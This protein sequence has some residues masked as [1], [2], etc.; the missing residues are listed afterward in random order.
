MELD[1]YFF[2]DEDTTLKFYTVRN[3]RLAA[4]VE[5]PTSVPKH[6]W[7]EALLLAAKAGP[8][9]VFRLLRKIGPE[10]LTDGSRKRKRSG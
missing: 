9:T 8:E 1:N 10:V 7:K 2:I 4:L 3:I 5:E 6:L